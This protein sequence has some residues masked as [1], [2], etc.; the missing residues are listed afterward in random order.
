MRAIELRQL[1]YFAI[2]GKEL[3]FGRAAA[4]AFVTQSALS[5]QVAKLE[6]LVG[7]QL[8]ERDHR[9]VTLTSAGSALLKETDQIFLQIDHALRSA[10]MAAGKQEFQL[11]IGLVEYTNLPF[12][13]P[14]L[15]RL[16]ALYPDVKI[17]KHEMNTVQQAAALAKGGID[18]G[19]GVLFSSAEAD[20]SMQVAPMLK[21]NWSV[22]IRRGSNLSRLSRLRVE[23][24]AAEKLIIFSRAVNPPLY[25][26]VV[27]DC[28]T[29]GFKPNFIYETLQSQVGIA[30]VHQ[31]LGVMLGATYVFVSIPDAL[32]YKIIDGFGPLVV[33]RLCR[34]HEANPLILDF[35]DI[36]AEEALAVQTRLDGY[37]ENGA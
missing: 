19:F 15:I 28:N 4:L 14:A 33:H 27:A 32:E 5:Q 8:F 20:S 3:H 31:G 23:D 37:L 22:L 11:S 13:P 7:V 17:S 2:L 29:A 21:A 26:S 18:I 35:M 24:L 1:R 16:Q 25:D 30:L 12:I 34:S 36:A 10:R 9:G 6:D